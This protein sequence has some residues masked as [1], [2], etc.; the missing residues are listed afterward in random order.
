MYL[1]LCIVTLNIW[2]VIRDKAIILNIDW[3]NIIVHI[4]F[5]I[6]I[7]VFTYAWSIVL[8]HLNKN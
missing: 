8:S 6:F 3:S 4:K 2:H 5:V 1:N 7:I